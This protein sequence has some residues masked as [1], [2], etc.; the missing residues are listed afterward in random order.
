MPDEAANPTLALT[1]NTY[2]Y[3]V[4]TQVP[5]EA[6]RKWLYE[7]GAL[8]PDAGKSGKVWVWVWVWVRV[9]VRLGLGLG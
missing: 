3:S 2:P 6:A 7:G 8:E 1:Y 9:R 4:P 5:D